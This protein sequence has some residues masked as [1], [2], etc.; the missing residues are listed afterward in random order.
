MTN[1]AQELADILDGWRV[2]SKGNSIRT[3]RSLH[4][5]SPDEWRGQVRAFG[6]LHEVDSY[7][8]SA[9]LGGR[10][11]DHYLRAYPQWAKALVA[12]DM[13]WSDAVTGSARGVVDQGSID[14]LRALGDIMDSSQLSVSLSPEMTIDGLAAVDA[15]LEAL[16]DPSVHLREAE[17]RYVY[18]LIAS[19]RRVFE[20][21]TVLGSV[22]LLGRVHELLGVMSLLA[23]TL[24]KDPQTSKLAKKIKDAARRIVPYASF[25]AKVGAGTIG[26]AADLLQITTGG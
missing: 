17:R 26:A 10:N 8:A 23:E 1:A 21:S 24:A 18:E 16:S 3:L 22:D 4:A 9:Q 5:D 20:E 15:L 19:V 25:G 7:L 6:L 11:V 2:V 14:V 13:L 12:P